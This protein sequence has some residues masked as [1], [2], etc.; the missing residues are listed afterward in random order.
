MKKIIAGKHF[1]EGYKSKLDF[2]ET[3]EG[4][5]FIKKHFQKALAD[6]LSLRR[7]SAPRFIFIDGGL[8][9]DLAGTQVPVGFKTTFSDKRVE[10]VHSLAKWKRHALAKYGFPEG[11]GLYT[12][13]DA[14]RKDEA[15]SP[16]HSVY[17]DQWDW[18]KVIAPEQRSLEFLKS[19][20][21]KIYEALRETEAEVCRKFPV[22][23]VRL[24]V[25][26]TFVHAEDLEEMYPDMTPDEREDAITKKFGVVFIIGIGEKLKS[27]Y[28]HD[29]RA[30]DYDD[31][32]TPTLDGKKGLNGDIIVWDDIRGKALEL[33]SMGIRVDP[34]SMK[35]QLALMG[36]SQR[37]SMEFHSGVIEGSIPPSIG[38]GIGQSRICMFLL[39]K[40]HIGEV[41]AGVWPEEVER[42]F[43]EQGVMLL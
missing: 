10:M 28:P 20:V 9:D 4:I 14:V 13:M 3:E 40:A 25:D 33:S 24:P 19:V 27:G 11:I 1:P 29:L 21:R 16:I 30:A 42:A 35:R 39:Q 5:H 6:R 23:K 12:D 34:E 22:L 31:W 38:G 37:E 43:E 8:Q 32:S 7:V 41:Q 18:E 26:I 15:V 2:F 36:L 17:V